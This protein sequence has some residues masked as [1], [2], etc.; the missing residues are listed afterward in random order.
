MILTL[1]RL[2]ITITNGPLKN[3]WKNKEWE[4]ERWRQKM[5]MARNQQPSQ[6]IKETDAGLLQFPSVLVTYI[7]ECTFIYI[8]FL[9][10]YCYLSFAFNQHEIAGLIH[11][12]FSYPVVW[13]IIINT[14]YYYEYNLFMFVP[15][16][17]C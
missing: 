8:L 9:F 10:N 14:N 13:Y 3:E 16:V 5:R 12:V 6:H 2:T 17:W 11:F 7:M 4:K 15:N 1:N